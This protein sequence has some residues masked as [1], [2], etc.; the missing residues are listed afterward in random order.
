MF[1]TGD[2]VR[3]IARGHSAYNYE[4]IIVTIQQNGFCNVGVKFNTTRTGFHDLQGQCEDGYGYWMF[5]TDLKLIR[6]EVESEMKNCNV[7]KEAVDR[8]ERGR[9]GEC[10]SKIKED[11]ADYIRKCALCG[12]KQNLVYTAAC[13]TTKDTFFFMCPN[14]YDDNRNLIDEYPHNK[15]RK[16]TCSCCSKKILDIRCR[17]RCTQCIKEAHQVICQIC[18]RNTSKLIF[19]KGHEGCTSCIDRM[20]FTCQICNEDFD[21]R[22]SN[23]LRGGGRACRSCYE[24]VAEAIQGYSYKPPAKFHPEKVSNKFRISGNKT[25]YLGIELEVESP[26]KSPAL[27]ASIVNKLSKDRAYS[28]GD[29]SISCG[30]EFVSHPM[31]LEY[32]SKKMNWEEI[33]KT[34]VENKCLSH[35]THTCG[36]HI[37]INKEFLSASDK[38]K[39]QVFINSHM[40]EFTTLARRSKNWARYKK[41]KE[42]DLKRVIPDG[43]NA[44]N[45]ENSNTVEIR[46]FKGTLRYSTFIASLQLIDAVAHYVKIMPKRADKAYHPQESWNGFIEYILDSNKP[47]VRKEG[48]KKRYEE[49]IAYMKSKKVF[50]KLKVEKKSIKEILKEIDEVNVRDFEDKNIRGCL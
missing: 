2:I 35:N 8:R 37:H 46:I 19:K 48:A 42:E 23:T 17:G 9:C 28:K 5:E 14:C 22:E 1:A 21:R 29:S 16:K 26:E 43:R 7:C 25:L 13:R 47:F 33:L 30:F 32:H 12:N 36:I 24:Q 40:K 38:I 39:F 45:W 15:L 18:D 4:G 20:F 50:S 11:K 10:I 31:S 34:L 27:M 44:V 49:L 41:I 6:R 3:V